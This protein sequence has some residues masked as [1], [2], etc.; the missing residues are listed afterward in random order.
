VTTPAFI[1]TIVNIYN[2][3]NIKDIVTI[4]FIT[5]AFRKGMDAPGW[6]AP[7]PS[8]SAKNFYRASL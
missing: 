1:L 4:L 3:I 5:F 8:S 2:I 7:T 6:V